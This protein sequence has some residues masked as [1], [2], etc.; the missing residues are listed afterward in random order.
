MYPYHSSNNLTESNIGDNKN[1][2]NDTHD[3]TTDH[4]YVEDLRTSREYGFNH[5]VGVI[6]KDDPHTHILNF[7]T[8]DTPYQDNT[9]EEDLSPPDI[10]KLPQLNESNTDQPSTS[11]A[12]KRQYIGDESILIEPI[13]KVIC[14]KQIMGSEKNY[15]ASLAFTEKITTASNLK[16]IEQ[17]KKHLDKSKIPKQPIIKKEIPTESN[18]CNTREIMCVERTCNTSSLSTEYVAEKSTLTDNKTLSI[19]PELGIV[20]PK[21]ISI[22]KNIILKPYQHHHINLWYTKTN[23]RIVYIDA[24]KKIVIDNNELFKRRVLEKIGKTVERRNL[25][26]SSINL[27]PTYSNIRKYVLDKISSLLEDGTVD[28]GILITPGMSISDLR[29]S[30]I[31]ND[32]FFKKLRKYCEKIKK[33]IRLTPNNNLSRIFQSGAIFNLNSTTNPT[34]IKVKFYSKKDRF[35][36]DLKELIIDTT[37][38]LPNNIISEIEKIDPKSIINSLFSDVHGVLASKSLIKNMNLLFTSN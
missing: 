28:S 18:S 20:E 35:I 10:F 31:S 15:I 9:N 6:A 25:L 8:H 17:T 32:M 16:N 21:K 33:D 4:V 36:P 5:C 29:S 1:V 30:C 12:L 22:K 3:N 2:R 7:C 11:S 19:T 24:I 34:N 23:S 37:S 38:N 26:K 27:S 13:S 14:L